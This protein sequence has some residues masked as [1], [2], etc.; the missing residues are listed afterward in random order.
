MALTEQKAATSADP[1]PAARGKR[2][3]PALAGN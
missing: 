3:G 2:G 1:A